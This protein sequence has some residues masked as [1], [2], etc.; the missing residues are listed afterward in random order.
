MWVFY[1]DTQHKHHARFIRYPGMRWT[2]VAFWWQVLRCFLSMVFSMMLSTKEY[3]ILSAA[4]FGVLCSWLRWRNRNTYLNKEIIYDYLFN[5]RSSMDRDVDFV[6]HGDKFMNSTRRCTSCVQ[7]RIRSSG[8]RRKFS[9]SWET[10]LICAWNPWT[11][12]MFPAR[13]EFLVVRTEALLFNN[14]KNDLS[15]IWFSVS[16][17]NRHSWW[18]WSSKRGAIYQCWLSLAS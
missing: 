3:P 17:S 5:G 13:P 10:F 11:A 7:M 12:R 18:T 8:L 1:T 6:Q 9:A 14:I 16:I 4:S 15:L 2:V